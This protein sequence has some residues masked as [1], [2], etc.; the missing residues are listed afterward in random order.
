MLELC[1]PEY[2][3][4]RCTEELFY[5]IRREKPDCKT[6]CHVMRQE[7]VDL[8]YRHEAVMVASDATLDRGMG[9]PRACGTFPRVLSRYVRGGILTLDDA[10]RRMTVLP[11]A[12]LGLS[13]K[14]R[15]SVGADADVVIF[16]PEKLIDRAT[17]EAPLTPPDGIELVFV[18]GKPVLRDGVILDRRAGKSVRGSRCT[19]GGHT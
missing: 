5:R 13:Q 6:V 15:L 2:F 17:F 1:L 16:D 19:Q 4:Q 7:D 10:I 11:A 9:H 3:G 12:Q 18:G 8:A 14:G